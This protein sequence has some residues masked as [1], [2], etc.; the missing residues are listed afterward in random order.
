VLYSQLILSDFIKFFAA[1][2]TKARKLRKDFSLI[3]I[4][5]SRLYV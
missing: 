3:R 1:A 5:L 4:C 2:L